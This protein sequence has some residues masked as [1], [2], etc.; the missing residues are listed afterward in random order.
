MCDYECPID[1]KAASIV[2]GGDVPAPDKALVVQVVVSLSPRPANDILSIDSLLILR[3]GIS[4]GF[5]GKDGCVWLVIV[6]YR[7]EV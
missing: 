1:D 3:C 6:R 4:L 2:L 5:G 7:F